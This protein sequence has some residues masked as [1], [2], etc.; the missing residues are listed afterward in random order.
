MSFA[1]LYIFRAVYYVSCWASGLGGNIDSTIKLQ[2]KPSVSSDQHK[3]SFMDL[4]DLK[5]FHTTLM[6]QENRCS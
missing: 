6:S 5:L 1:K 3:L 2:E 4:Q